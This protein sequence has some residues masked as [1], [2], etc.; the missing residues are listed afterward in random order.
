MPTLKFKSPETQ[1]VRAE[2][3]ETTGT[4]ELFLPA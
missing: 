3:V 2:C 4:R 1:E